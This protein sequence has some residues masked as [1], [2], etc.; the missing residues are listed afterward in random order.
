MSDLQPP[1][2]T[3]LQSSVG[4]G[5]APLQPK[6]HSS[7]VRLLKA[8][9]VPRAHPVLRLGL[10]SDPV[11]QIPAAA[12]CFAALCFRFVAGVSRLPS[13]DGFLIPYKTRNEAT[14]YKFL[15]LLKG[16]HHGD[17]DLFFVKVMSQYFQLFTK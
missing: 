5:Y 3:A 10:S 8:G 14:I 17:L 15:L 11:H 1:A 6:L 9:S 4:S 16:K 12:G 2:G 13:S 7:C